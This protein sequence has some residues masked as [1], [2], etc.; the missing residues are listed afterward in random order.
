MRRL[1]VA[2]VVVLVRG[3]RALAWQTKSARRGLI[4]DL[5]GRPAAGVREGRPLH[6]RVWRPGK[7]G[8][9]SLAPV[10]AGYKIAP[11]WHPPM[12]T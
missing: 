9:S 12:S 5:A 6:S 3:G 1:L 10:A 2:V 8:I 7:P 4:A 11:H